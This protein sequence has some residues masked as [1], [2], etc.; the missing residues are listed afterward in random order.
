MQGRAVGMGHIYGIVPLFLI[1]PQQAGFAS[2]KGRSSPAITSNH[3]RS[4]AILITT[5]CYHVW[6]LVHTL[7]GTGPLTCLKCLLLKSYHVAVRSNTWQTNPRCSM[8]KLQA[9]LGQQAPPLPP[10]PTA[11]MMAHAV[12]YFMLILYNCFKSMHSSWNH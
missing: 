4:S 5:Y 8:Q 12:F 9:L 10:S 2:N 1:C 11:D 7:K 3:K 6:P